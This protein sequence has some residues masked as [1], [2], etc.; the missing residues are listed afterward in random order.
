MR[1]PETLLAHC[2]RR[3]QRVAAS[4]VTAAHFRAELRTRWP[5]QEQTARDTREVCRPTPSRMVGKR[6]S[7]LPQDR[8]SLGQV[9]VERGS[10]SLPRVR[11]RIPS[12]SG[13]NMDR[14][15]ETSAR[16]F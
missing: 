3:D 16:R 8:Y 5:R 10:Q 2:H 13:Y 15:R 1:P 12:C 11:K 14:V 4:Q 6:W 9:G 7:R